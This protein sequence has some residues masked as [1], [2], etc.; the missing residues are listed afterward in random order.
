MDRWL[1]AMFIILTEELGGDMFDSHYLAILADT[2]ESRSLH[3]RLRYQVYCLE[4]QYESKDRFNDGLE[5]DSFDRHSIHFLIR[6][7]AS[8]CWVGAARLVLGEPDQLP[9]AR[10]AKFSL[11]G[12]PRAGKTF[13]ELSRLSILK[14]F[15]RCGKQQTVS[16]PE[17]LLGLIRAAK[18]YSEQAKIDYWLFL[19]RRSIMRIVGNLGMHMD[20]IGEPCEHRGV[21][22]PY[23]A[24]LATAFDGIAQR[25]EAVHA[26][27]SRKNTLI[28]YS[29]LQSGKALALA[30]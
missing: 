27:F 19:C 28:P 1:Y 7:K 29:R 5:T 21:R 13:A 25:S 10:L 20:V 17:V 4:K 23:L 6:H 15:R 9:M 3:Y 22:V 8:G 2:P 26:M 16:E 18:E 12:Y 30:A 24:V 14:S 11:A